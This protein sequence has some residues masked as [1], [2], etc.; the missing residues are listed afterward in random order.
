MKNKIDDERTICEQKYNKNWIK[1]L[2]RYFVR[3]VIVGSI[4]M[5]GDTDSDSQETEL[6]ITLYY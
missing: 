6:A 2:V 3:K 1:T 5:Q 4:S